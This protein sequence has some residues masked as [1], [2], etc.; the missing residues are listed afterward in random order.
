M[1]ALKIVLDKINLEI[2]GG[3][4]TKEAIDKVCD[5]FGISKDGMV[6]TYL[7]GRFGS[8]MTIK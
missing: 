8:W 5:E 2:K 4:S 3:L 7:I 1:S 6:Y